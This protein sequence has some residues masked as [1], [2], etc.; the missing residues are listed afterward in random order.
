[1]R[2]HAVI[3]RFDAVCEIERWHLHWHGWSAWLLWLGLH[4][5]HIIGTRNRLLTLLDWGTDYLRHS[6]AVEIIRS[7][8]DSSDP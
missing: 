3:G 5:Y 6:A 8:P 7:P 2:Q 4:L 1:P